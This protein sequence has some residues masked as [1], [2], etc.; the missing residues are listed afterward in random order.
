MAS[1]P[2]MTPEQRADALAKAAVARKARADVKTSLKN[3]S[4]TLDE[5]MKSAKDSDI[6]G[7]MKVSAVLASLPG[8][9]KVRAAQV[10]ERLKIAEGRRLRGLGARQREALAEEF[11]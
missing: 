9:G 11:A 7:G 5:V 8:L 4:L 2:P 1:L 3:G 6:V 10:M